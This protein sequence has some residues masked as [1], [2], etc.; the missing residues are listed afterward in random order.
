MNCLRCDDNDLAV[1]NYYLMETGE[2][3]VTFECRQC[4]F[5]FNKTMS[6]TEFNEYR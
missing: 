4:C 5:Q 1:I 2:F 6:E 3:E